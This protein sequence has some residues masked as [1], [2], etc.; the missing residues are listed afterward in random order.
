MLNWGQL[1][2]VVWCIALQR[3]APAGL[4]QWHRNGNRQRGGEGLFIADPSAESNAYHP[5][6]GGS[7]WSETAQVARGHAARGAPGEEP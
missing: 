6:V 2:K 5:A 1:P 3:A 7:R 4:K